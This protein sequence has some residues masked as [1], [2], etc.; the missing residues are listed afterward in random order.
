[1]ETSGSARIGFR[2]WLLLLT[3]FA[4]V[5]M[6]LFSVI[7]L[8]VLTDSQREV[9]KIRLQ[10]AAAAL[11]GTLERHLAA[12]AAMLAAIASS[13]AARKGDLEAVYG[14]A[15]RIV[16][17]SPGLLAIS[18]VDAAGAILFNTMRPYGAALPESREP[19]AAR[20]VIETG[21]PRVS[22]AFE[23]TISHRQVTVLGVPLTVNGHRRYCLRAVLPVTEL[24]AILAQQ[25]L[26]EEWDCSVQ[27]ATRPV[28]ACGSAAAVLDLPPAAKEAVAAASRAGGGDP[29]PRL[30]ETAVA[31]VGDWGWSVAVSVPE[32]AFVAPLRQMVTK[33]SVA[34][35]LCLLFAIAASLWLARRLSRDMTLLAADSAD[36]A[37]GM[38]VLDSGII[39]REM[40]E[41]RACL[42]AAHEREEQAL[43]D[44][45]TGLAGRARFWELARALAHDAHND[46]ELGVAVLFIDLDG[47]KHVNDRHGHARG[48]WILERTAEALRE[49]TRDT[50]VTGRLGGDEFAV[51]LTARG[52]HLRLAAESIAG[53]VVAKVS[54]LGYGIGCS[55]G[56]SLCTGGTADL[57]RCLNL[58]DQA[59]YEAKRLGK[60]RFVTREDASEG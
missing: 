13:D 49:S 7:S 52:D 11:A 17:G 47:F 48:D 24:E 5:P 29:R 58:A 21:R 33:F 30:V 32:D 18:L 44:P 34:G 1:M 10:R 37:V 40:G 45:L 56:V 6:L 46:P 60:N 20:L 43:H 4:C 25:H 51:C 22:G 57:E 23:G 41:V 27:D 54:R 39:I 26:P 19:F 59:M 42:L 31:H 9:E 35:A 16:S 55:I 28:A 15:A 38:P 12:R 14:H 8:I 2:V 36:P 50:D 3:L 53:R